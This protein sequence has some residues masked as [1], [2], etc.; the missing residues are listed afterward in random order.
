MGA[1]GTNWTH[2]MDG[3]EMS[4]AG[5]PEQQRLQDADEQGVAWRRWG[6]YLSERQ[7]GTVREDYSDNGDA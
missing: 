6:P 1:A 5:N 3:E 2:D 7:W 4:A